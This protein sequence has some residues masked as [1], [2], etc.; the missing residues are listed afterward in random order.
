MLPVF[1][2]LNAREVGF[3]DPLEFQVNVN[4]IAFYCKS[5]T[6][7]TYVS[8]TNGCERTVVESY[9][10]VKRLIKEAGKKVEVNSYA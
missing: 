3:D 5:A 10:Q 9:D 7:G 6:I 8:F 1:I 2:T 4:N